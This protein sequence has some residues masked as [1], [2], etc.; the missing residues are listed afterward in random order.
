MGNTYFAALRLLFSAHASDQLKTRRGVVRRGGLIFRR[1]KKKKNRPRAA[2]SLE[3]VNKLPPRIGGNDAPRRC[4]R[5]VMPMQ[6]HA[7][8]KNGLH[9]CGLCPPGTKLQC[10]VDMLLIGSNIYS[11]AYYACCF[12]NAR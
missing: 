11:R 4:D 10:S 5:A 8:N 9:M 6:R 3:S 12:H 1:K 2:L 7:C